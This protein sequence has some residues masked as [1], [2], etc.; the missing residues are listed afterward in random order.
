MQI[1]Q[2]IFQPLQEPYYRGGYI[3]EKYYHECS[4]CG[5]KVLQD[6]AILD[7]HMRGNHN[8]DINEYK[9]GNQVMIQ[10]KL[11]HSICLKSLN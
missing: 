5:K 2:I 8:I 4:M 6:Y 3:V 10:L 9:V 11:G 1:T 7:K